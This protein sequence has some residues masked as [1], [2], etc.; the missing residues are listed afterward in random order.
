[1]VSMT[2]I[3]F[4]TT[5][6]LGALC[7]WR[8]MFVSN[9][10]KEEAGQTISSICWYASAFVLFAVGLIWSYNEQVS[11]L[12]VYFLESSSTAVAIVILLVLLCLYAII[13]VWLCYLIGTLIFIDHFVLKGRMLPQSKLTILIQNYGI[14]SFLMILALLSYFESIYFLF[15]E[16]L[17][18]GFLSTFYLSTSNIQ[19][20]YRTALQLVVC[21]FVL[22]T[23][24]IA[25]SALVSDVLPNLGVYALVLSGLLSVSTFCAYIGIRYPNYRFRIPSLLACI[26]SITM[27]A[28]FDIVTGL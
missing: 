15:G 24:G 18:L 3:W 28:S 7:V 10:G 27:A 13:S 9:K 25:L 20:V 5:W 2:A 12:Y 11:E 19:S 6:C 17:Y 16:A 22:V 23:L 1:M 26:L 8:A 14:L 21:L 4:S